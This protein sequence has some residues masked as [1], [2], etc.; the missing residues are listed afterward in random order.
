[1]TAS[2]F[3]AVDFIEQHRIGLPNGQGRVNKIK[4]SSGQALGV[5]EADQ[6][7]E[8]KGRHLIG[9]EIYFGS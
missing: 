4:R 6:V 8:I 7:I 5:H 3:G 9:P 1:M 2:T